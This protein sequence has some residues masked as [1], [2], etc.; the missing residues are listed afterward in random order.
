MDGTQTKLWETSKS[1]TVT[2][3]T[4]QDLPNELALAIFSLLEL[5]SYIVLHGVCKKWKQLL[6]S[7][8]IH[9]I[10]RRMFNLFHHML[11]HPRFPETRPWT[12]KNLRTSFNRKAYIDALL[13]KYR[14]VPEEF[15]LWIL[16]WPARM[17]SFG[18]WPGLPVTFH[19]ENTLDKAYGMNWIA[20]R[21]EDDLPGYYEVLY[22][23]PSREDRWLPA[24]QFWQMDYGGSWLIFGKDDPDLFGRVALLKVR[25][26]SPG[27]HHIR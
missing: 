10:R 23:H 14:A 7:A 2:Q 24:L 15:R 11:Q 13:S 18:M 25:L 4:F 12:L 26:P 22:R 27:I 8:D 3:H 1:S 20:W 9:P 21:T 5:K 6:P 19:K 16:E 17:V